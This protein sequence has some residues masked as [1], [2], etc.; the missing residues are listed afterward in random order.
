MLE[1]GVK[2]DEAKQAFHKW[3]SKGKRGKSIGRGDSM[4]GNSRI[5]DNLFV[6]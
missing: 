2:E 6:T 5:Y 4:N 3:G 1:T